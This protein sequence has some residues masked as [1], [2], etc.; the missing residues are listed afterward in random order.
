MRVHAD[1]ARCEGHG[2]CAI[3]APDVFALDEDGVVQI[4]TEVVAD[5]AR[6]RAR[7][8]VDACPVAA[9]SARDESS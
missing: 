3:V 2:Q 7:A 4:L 5:E 1:V 9:L 6:E 8:G